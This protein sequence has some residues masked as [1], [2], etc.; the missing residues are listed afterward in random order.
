MEQFLP[1]RAAF[2]LPRIWFILIDF[3]HTNYL[4]IYRTDVSQIMCK[5]GRIWM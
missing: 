4:N 1:D 5:T 2:L 3:C